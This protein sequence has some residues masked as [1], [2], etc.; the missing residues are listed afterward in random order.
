MATKLF[1]GAIVADIHLRALTLGLR[2]GLED[3][4]IRKQVDAVVAMFL[5]RYRYR[6]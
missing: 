5:A 1:L 6:D 4:E 2:E 3:S